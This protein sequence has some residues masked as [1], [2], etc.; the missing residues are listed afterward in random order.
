MKRILLTILVAIIGLNASAQLSG[1]KNVPGDYATLGAAI[2]ALNTNGVAPGGVTINVVAGNAQTAPLVGGAGSVAG[3][4]G[5]GYVIN[6]TG[7]YAPSAANPVVIQGNGNTVTS[8]S[9]GAAATNYNDAIFTIAGTSYVTI[10]NFRMREN[11]AN[12]TITASNNCTEFG[13]AIVGA[14]ISGTHVGSQNCFVQGCNILL[15]TTYTC[16]IGIY[17]NSSNV[18]TTAYST[19]NNPTTTGGANSYNTYYLDTVQSTTSGIVLLGNA[20]FNDLNTVVGAL[21]NGDTIVLGARTANMVMATAYV[22]YGKTQQDG[23]YAINNFNINVNYDQVTLSVGSTTNSEQGIYINT[24]ATGSTFTTQ[25]TRNHITFRTAYA[26]AAVTAAG[27]IRNGTGSATNATLKINNNWITMN[28]ASTGFDFYGIYNSGAALV[29][30]INNNTVNDTTTGAEIFAIYNTGAIGTLTINSNS[31]LNYVTATDGDIY[32]IYNTGVCTT[33]NIDNN[34]LGVRMTAA[35]AYSQVGIIT[36]GAISNAS[37]SNNN[38]NINAPSVTANCFGIN[39]SGA[40]ATSGTFSSD[41]ITISAVGQA[42]I[43]TGAIGTATFNY[44]IISL[45]PVGTNA[46][47]GIYHSTGAITSGDFSYNRISSPG[48][49]AGQFAGVYLLSGTITTATVTNNIINTTNSGISYGV[50]R[51]ASPG[52]TYTV[53]NNSI[54]LKQTATGVNTFGSYC[55][56]TTAI[57]NAFFNNNTLD[58]SNTAAATASTYFL[59]TAGA[60]NASGVKSTF[61]NNTFKSTFGLA[62]TSGNILLLY[63]ANEN[64]I[65]SI[66]GN[67]TSGTI[68]KTGSGGLFY[69]IYN[70][71]AGSTFNAT[72]IYGNNMSNISVAGTTQVYAIYSATYAGQ[73]R[74]IA[75]DTMSNITASTGILSGIIADYCASTT[76]STNCYLS[77]LSG[78]GNVYGISYATNTA[79]GTASVNAIGG[80]INDNVVTGLSSSNASATVMGINL[81]GTTTSVF[82]AYNNNLGNFSSSGN[83]APLLYGIYLPFGVT[84]NLYNNVIHDFTTT[85]GGAANAKIYGIHLATGV[86]TTASIYK[87]TLYN[88]SAGNSGGATTQVNGIYLPGNTASL[89]HNVYN[90][91]LS[92]FS[93]ASATNPDA[94]VGINMAATNPTWNLYYNTLNLQSLGGGVNFGAAGILFPTGTTLLTLKNNIINM[95]SSG[96]IAANGILAC[97]RRNV[98]GTGGT[99]PATSNYDGNYNIYSVNSG[100]R[101]YFYAEQ[102]AGG[103][104]TNGYNLTTDANFNS[105]NALYKAY[106]ASG[107]ESQSYYENNLSSLSTGVFA[108]T[109]SSYAYQAGLQITSPAITDDY[110]GVTRNNPPCIGSLEF[111]GSYPASGAPVITYSALNPVS[112]CIAAPPTLSAVITSGAGVN[113]TN[114]TKPR[115]YYKGSTDANAYNGNTN[116]VDGWKWVEA[117]NSSSPF[118]F[119]PDYSLILTA[120]APAAGTAMSYFVVAQDNNVVPLVASKTVGYAA[121][122]C[123]TSVALTSGAFPTVAAPTINSYVITAIPSFTSASAPI[124]FCGTTNPATLSLSPNAADLLVQWQNDYGSGYTNI[125]GGTSSTYLATPPTVGGT[126][127]TVNYRANLT[128]NASV[129]ATSS[130]TATSLYNP[131]VT[132]STPADRCGTGTVTLAATGPVG[133]VLEWFAASTGGA[134]LGTGTTFTTPSISTNTIYYVA[135]SFGYYGNPQTVGPITTAIGSTL[136]GRFFGLYNNAGLNFT[137]NTPLNLQSVDIFPNASGQS[138]SIVI[139]NSSGTIINTIAGTTTVS[140]GAQTVTLNVYLVPGTYQMAFGTLGASL[141]PYFNTSGYSFPYNANFNTLS[142]TSCPIAGYYFYFYNWKVRAGCTSPRTAV[143]ATINPLPTAGTISATPNPVCAGSTLTLSETGTP[144]GSGSMASYNWSGPNSYA[145]SG[146]GTVANASFAPASTLASGIYSLTVTY[147]GTGCT[148]LPASSSYVTVNASTTPVIGGTLNACVGATSNLT[149]S[150]PSG[151]WLS[152]NTGVATINASLGIVTAVSAGTTTISYTS[153]CGVVATA[154]FTTNSTPT[155]ITGV[156][157]LCVS[158]VTTMS[159]GT[160][161]GTWSSTN[162]FAASINS[163]TGVVTSGASSG[164]TTISYVIG[165]CG[166]ASALNISNNT[167]GSITGTTTLCVGG[168]TTLACSPLGGTWSSSN[169]ALATINS[170]GVVT[171]VS[172]G[173]PNITYSTGCGTPSVQAVTVSGSSITLSTNGPLCSGT[174][175]SLSAAL[176]GSGT[177]SW[178][179]PNSFSSAL[180]NPTIANV[181]TAASGTY[182]FTATVSGCSNSSTVFLAV[183]ASPSVTVS[184]SPSAICLGGVTSLTDVVSA[185]LS[186]MIN[187]IPYS[188]ATLTSP[189]TLTSGSSWTGGND[190]GYINVPLNFTF[191]MFGTNYTTVNISANG[192]VNFGTLSASFASSPVTLPSTGSSVPKNMISLFWHDMVVNSGSITYGVMGTAPN[193]TFIINYNAIP[194]ASG[195]NTN[196]GQVVLHETTNNIEVMV[197]STASSAK[198]CGIQN[199]AGTSALT[200]VGE[201]NATYAITPAAPQGWRFSTPSYNYAWTPAT[202]LSSTT[203]YNPVVTGLSASQVYSVTTADIYSSCSGLLSSVGVTVNPVPTVASVTPSASNLCTGGSI[204]LTAGSVSGGVGSF[205]SY[206]WSGPGGYSNTVTSVSTV[207]VSATPG[208][209]GAYSVVANYS[210]SGCAGTT[211]A[212]SSVV[213]VT[214]QPA[215]TSVT[216]SFTSACAGSSLTITS[217]ATGG[218]GTSK[219]TWSGASIATTTTSTGT[220]PVFSPTLAGTNTYSVVLH[221]DGVGCI[222]NGSTTSVT[223][224]PNPSASVSAAMPNICQPTTAAS[225]GLCSILGAPTTYSVVWNATAISDGGFSNI[226]AATLS[227]SSVTLIYNPSGGAGSFDGTLTLSNGSCT[228]A[229]YPVH[230][231]VHAEPHVAVAAINTP[232]VGYAGSIVFT[233]TDSASVAYKIDGGSTVNFLFAGTTHTLSTGAITSAHNYL[234]VD[235]HNAVCTT[236]TDPVI[237]TTITITPTPMAWVGGTGG[238][239]HESEWNRITNWSCGFVPTVADDVQISAAA[240]NPVVPSSFTATTRNLTVSSGGV[241]V[242]DG[243]SEVDVKGSY[244]N[245]AQ[246]LGAG[247]VVLNGGSAQAITGIGTTNNLVLDNSSGATINTGSR[248]IIGNTITI[249]SGTLTTNDSLELASTDTN[250]TARIAQ[251]PSSGAAITG[252]VKVDQYV[253]GGYRRF[254]FFSHPFS[255]TMSL[256]QLQPYIDITGPGGTANGFRYTASNS[257]SAFRLDPYTENSSMGYDPG[258]KPFTRINA[259]AADS[260]KVHPGQG[261]RFLIRGAKGEG[262]GYLGYIG[263]YTVSPT[264]FKMMGNVNQGDISVNL[265]QGATPTLQSYNMVGNPYASPVDMGTVIWNARAA[266]QV[267]GGAFFVFDPSLGAGGQ[268]VPVN[269]SGSPI[270]YYVQANTCIQV[271]ADHDGAHIDFTEADKSATTSNYLYKTPVQYTKLNVYDENYHTWDMLQFDFNDKAT[272]ENDRMLDAVK[273]MGISDF[274]FYSQAADNSKLAVDSRPFV[275]EKVIPLGITSGYQQQFI[276]RADN[277]VVPA[278][279]QLVLHDKLLGKYVDLNQ[280]TEYAFTI[281]KDKASQGDRFELGLKSTVPLPVKPFAVSMTP[282]PTTDDVKISFTSGKKDK[283]TVRVMD[284]SGVSIYSK[285]LGEQQDGT[286]SVPLSSFAAGFYMVELTQGDQK[287]T[288]RLVKE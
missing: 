100:A 35:S 156:T 198:T 149:T 213:T 18:F 27:A 284:I 194:D 151:T 40:L 218:V 195:L 189:T 276:I 124:N 185:P 250:A 160:G 73:A 234:I 123:P 105:C 272:D 30:N 273:P 138:F 67:R 3:S 32:S 270:P 171:G 243:S 15:S 12:T 144:V 86:A 29:A 68:S 134:P 212:V 49:I 122:Y 62:T 275:A 14:T 83:T 232:C 163:S 225:V 85:A 228:S 44:N 139:Y 125:S 278:G 207:T 165:S 261:I 174:T 56:P 159:N 19:A 280:G 53:S 282:N 191:N 170:S 43:N 112:Y 288:Q 274:N 197:S 93:A 208:A 38:I 87:N 223:T 186:F 162:T 224:N 41:T 63:C 237:G 247:K 241:L 69:G 75:Y 37:F 42:L 136:T 262:L 279:G 80:I 129:V 6:I 267:M 176:G 271:Q 36:S 54:T 106:M 4:I 70:A 103:A 193:R 148:S 2:A 22:N 94:V 1:T 229:P 173:T 127:A 17:S 169:T 147:P 172:T 268:F 200:A 57:P 231:I 239:G 155:A 132:T 221:Y 47:Y 175:A 152:T 51:G 269:L 126:S 235:V 59:Y 161:G 117:S 142:I 179:G 9:L 283:V 7:T 82:S 60:A 121:G 39:N 277:V 227:G 166:V 92:A 214:P 46:I 76:V 107:R 242:I 260:N 95:T 61:L 109:S 157:D 89:I 141:S 91:N 164:T 188:L 96:T 90:N 181:T 79:P 183:D 253:M 254:R 21:N 81:N 45:S 210:G 192:Y 115:L 220:S 216:P 263:G 77:S 8:S 16:N 153:P 177:Y 97:V 252:Q 187:A 266:G 74:L 168:N 34:T 130:A 50:Y 65:D 230:T 245:S 64:P 240:F 287:T 55:S 120:H 111:A 217:T 146:T 52:T 236:T 128:C 205:V 180:Q 10:K 66:C 48:T 201:N 108:P 20:S 25:I 104:L 116:A 101:N 258:W 11:A 222:D 23:I 154:T 285:D 257:P 72:T 99:A 150:V 204:T 259:G 226:S 184:A 206:V 158:S 33:G 238:A 264:T 256:S 28:V 178:T 119:T 102:T 133:T 135:D 255:D 286:I 98:S 113:T 140:S 13:V 110:A 203:I 118:I 143:T 88:L 58:L 137:V 190:D 167:P 26:P 31:S 202:A 5:A 249:T 251:I 78:A 114:G 24:C 209:T 131:T 215:I 182:S 196:S 281:G 233:G 265:A 199:L 84:P 145:S 71:G 219:Y 246:V 248:L 211:P 244:N